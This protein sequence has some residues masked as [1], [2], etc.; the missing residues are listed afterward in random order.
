MIV[1]IGTDLI[2]VDRVSACLDRHQDRFV[3]RILSNEEMRESSGLNQR[4]LA[5]YMAKRFVAKES[6][7]K[8]I[9]TGLALGVSW[10]DISVLNAPSGK[11][12][13][14][15]AGRA[16]ELIVAQVNSSSYTLHLSI[17][18]TEETAQAIAIIESLCDVCRCT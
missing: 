2:N 4:V 6:L 1:G 15:V 3:D 7:M 8:A 12:V 13:F 5:K 18:D 17:T 10:K 16:R 11:P 14:S 9:G